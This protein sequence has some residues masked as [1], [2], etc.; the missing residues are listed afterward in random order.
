MQEKNLSFTYQVELK[1][2]SAILQKVSSMVYAPNENE[3]ERNIKGKY[4]DKLIRI[5]SLRQV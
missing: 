1:S 4:G 5:I 2:S 3:A